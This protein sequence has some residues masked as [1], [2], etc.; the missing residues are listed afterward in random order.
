M[1]DGKE[2]DGGPV[3]AVMAE[4]VGG[5]SAVVSEAKK[6]AGVV[7]RALSPRP[8]PQA[9]THVHDSAYDYISLH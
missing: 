8:A 5:G 3:A 1:E 4:W 2:T 9:L 7:A 6:R